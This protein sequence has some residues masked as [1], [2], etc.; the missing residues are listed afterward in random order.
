[1]IRLISTLFIAAI[2]WMG[3]AVSAETSRISKGTKT[4]QTM[5]LH[6]VHFVGGARDS[7]KGCPSVMISNARNRGLE[8]WANTLSEDV[9]KLAAELETCLDPDKENQAFI[10]LGDKEDKQS[11]A[12]IAKKYK[13]NKTTVCVPNS[14]KLFRAAKFTEESDL[15]VFFMDRKMIKA[16]H[17]LK[18][19]ELTEAKRQDLIQEFREFFNSSK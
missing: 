10:I 18:V 3:F 11:L 1:M 17:R 14:Q 5:P 13:L 9:F 16:K 15:H 2:C 8:I 19:S 7:G 6:V 4:G 12:K